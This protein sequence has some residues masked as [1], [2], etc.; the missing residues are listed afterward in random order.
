MDTKV[1]EVPTRLSYI[2]T[3]KL[4]AASVFGTLV[5]INKAELSVDQTA[6]V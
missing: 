5:P 3:L 4:E 6:S 1:F 2:L